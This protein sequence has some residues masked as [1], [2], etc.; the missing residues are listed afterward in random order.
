MAT[1]SNQNSNEK[2]STLAT[3]T[4][5]CV[6][7]CCVCK[8]RSCSGYKTSARTSTRYNLRRKTLENRARLAFWL[9]SRFFGSPRNSFAIL[10]CQTVRAKCLADQKQCLMSGRE[11]K[12]GNEMQGEGGGGRVHGNRCNCR[13]LSGGE[14]GRNTQTICHSSCILMWKTCRKL[15]LSVI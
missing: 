9:T 3:H 1:N 12:R 11:G 8:S 2:N 13:I 14:K 7:V 10:K 4:A 15:L 6:C 5:V